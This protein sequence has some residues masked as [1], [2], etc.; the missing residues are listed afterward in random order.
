MREKRKEIEGKKEESGTGGTEEKGK[1]E[2]GRKGRTRITKRCLCK[3]PP[4]CS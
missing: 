4:K 2:K 3:E 1:L